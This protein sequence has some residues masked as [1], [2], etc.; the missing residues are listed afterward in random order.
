MGW[1]ALSLTLLHTSITRALPISVLWRTLRSD[2]TP[3]SDTSIFLTQILVNCYKILYTMSTTATQHESIVFK[4]KLM[5][6]CKIM[7]MADYDLSECPNEGSRPNVGSTTVV[8]EAEL[9]PLN[10]FN[11]I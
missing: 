7:K 9:S 8:L 11:L 10:C 5:L 4:V 2:R 1:P 6:C 3:R